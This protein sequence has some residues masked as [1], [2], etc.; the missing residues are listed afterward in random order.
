MWNAWQNYG[1]S[2]F[3]SESLEEAI[4]WL[5]LSEEYAKIVYE[6]VQEGGFSFVFDDSS[7]L[8]LE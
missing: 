3:E 5:E 1:D 4:E 2:Y 8:D 6:T 7:G